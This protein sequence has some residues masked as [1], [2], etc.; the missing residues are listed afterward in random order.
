MDYIVSLYDIESYTKNAL[1]VF[2]HLHV[3]FRNCA[4]IASCVRMLW[5]LQRSCV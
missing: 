1:L 4:G 3:S 5:F 2:T